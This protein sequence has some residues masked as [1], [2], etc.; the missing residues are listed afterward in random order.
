[1]IEILKDNFFIALYALTWIFSIIRL[2]KYF[3]S[4][5]KYL[6]II[7]GYTLFTEI[8]GA[9]IY[10][11]EDFTLFSEKQ[12]SSYTHLIYNIYDL[13]FF[14]F[15]FYVYWKSSV[16]LRVKKLIKYGALF[17]ILC[18]IVNIVLVNSMK[19]E[20]WYAYLVGSVILILSTLTYLNSIWSNSVTVYSNLLFWL[21]L[22]LLIFHL[23]YA[24]ITIFKNL[25]LELAMEDYRNVRLVHISLIF[26]MYTLFSI[27]LLKMKRVTK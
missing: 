2:P 13:I 8:L 5:L 10:N 6:P 9:L 15:F 27:G 18:F 4:T 12:F 16:N 7:I 14:S 22:G 11:V 19:Y 24:P 20:L 1:V 23:G 25:N 3:D 21:S 26:I 17:F